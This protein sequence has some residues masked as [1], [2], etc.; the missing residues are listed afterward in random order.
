MSSS[1][2]IFHSSD[3]CNVFGSS[4]QPL[5]HFHRVTTEAAQGLCLFQQLHAGIMLPHFAWCQWMSL[6]LEEDSIT[7]YS[8]ILYSVKSAPCR[9]RH[10]WMSTWDDACVLLITFSVGF[11]SCRFVGA[12]NT[13]DQSSLESKVLLCGLLP[14]GVLP[15]IPLHMR[16]LLNILISSSTNFYSE[17]LSLQTVRFAFYAIFALFY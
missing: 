5:L 7:L 10:L 1:W 8:S 6:T 12:E 14:W 2:Q 16:P 3:I 4:A 13:L 17:A 15:F 11:V 9:R